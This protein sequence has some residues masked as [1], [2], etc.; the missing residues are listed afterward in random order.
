LALLSLAP[1]AGTWWCWGL[2]EQ[3][4]AKRAASLLLFVATRTLALGVVGI[5]VT[6]IGQQF[7]IGQK[8]F[9][10]L[11]GATYVVLGALYFAGKTGLLM[12]RLGIARQVA[13]NR[14]DAVMM[15]V[16]FGLSV[17]ACAALVRRCRQCCR[18]RGVCARIYY[19]RAVGARALCSS[20]GRVSH[21]GN[22][23]RPRRGFSAYLQ[24]G[25]AI[26]QRERTFRFFVF[27]QWSG[28]AAMMALP[29]YVVAAAG[30]GF[31]VER[32]P[33]LLSAQT[34]GSLAAIPLWGW[35]GDRWGK[36]S[37]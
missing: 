14:R 16:L 19:P 26:F 27:A 13:A 29:F 9:W 25:L 1:L 35:W 18:N 7:I 23:A 32:V 30:L 15:G 4:K 3:P 6:L 22:R 12:Q 10:L 31:D 17:P 11:F 36:R 20:S 28:A 5:A 37:L 21:R 33:L 8:A 34:L 2:A 24:D